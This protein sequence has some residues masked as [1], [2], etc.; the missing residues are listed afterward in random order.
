MAKSDR[1]VPPV[2]S[3]SGVD[4]SPQWDQFRFSSVEQD[5]EDY[6]SFETGEGYTGYVKTSKPKQGRR[7]QSGEV[8]YS[9]RQNQEGVRR[10]RRGLH[11]GD[12]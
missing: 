11:R 2:Y 1:G 7:A 3:E 10:F 12:G 8:V 5:L 6:D 4:S 9:R